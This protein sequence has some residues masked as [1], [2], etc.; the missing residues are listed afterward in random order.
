MRQWVGAGRPAGVGAGEAGGEAGRAGAGEAGGEAG[1]VGAGEAG[2]EA[3]RAGAGEAGGAGDARGVGRP[4]TG[5]V[6]DVLVP[7]WRLECTREI[8]IV[9]EVA[10]MWGYRRIERSL[11]GGAGAQAGSVG[12]TARQR[13][14]RRVRQALAGA[15][16]DEAWTT[17]FLAPGDLERA[18]LDPDAVEVENPLD[19]SES[20][21]RTALIPGLLKAV[22]FN[23]DRQAGDVCL[24]EI[25]RV[26]AK[27]AAGSGQVTPDEAEHLGVIIALGSGEGTG[28]AGGA[29]PAGGASRSDDS[30]PVEGQSGRL[31]A[32]GEAEAATRTWLWLSDALR[33]DGA[34][35][36]AD[37][38]PGWHPTRAAR[39]LGASG[40]A[41]GAVGELDPD[42]VAAYGLSGRIGFMAV[43]LDDLGEEP[44]VPKRAK[45]VSRYP[46]SDLD[47]AFLVS[48]EV[49]AADVRATIQSAGSELL[50]SVTLFDVYRGAQAGAGRRSLA[51]RL[52]F[53][54][55]DRTLT[56]A[57]LAT[58][59]RAVVDAVEG[60]HG[61]ELRS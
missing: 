13:E 22:K 47:L 1:R 17:T 38:I 57:E 48:E 58:L 37:E 26:F 25:G 12:L 36:R 27:P 3:G 24:F 19:A 28:G 16:F 61:G 54:A 34:S 21:L 44:R 29:P 32:G 6:H 35:I 46:A 52:R 8:D 53:R 42:V 9:E 11:P 56:D 4:S 59:R 30:G 45:D 15:G 18:R 33:L 39:I 2:G 20:L 41:L 51:F 10:R 40:Q 7:S 14:R 49:P 43:S 50:E 5:G 60:A 31:V 55:A 23:I